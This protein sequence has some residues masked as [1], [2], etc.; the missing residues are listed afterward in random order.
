MKVIEIIRRVKIE[1]WGLLILVALIIVASM[2]RTF[3]LSDQCIVQ[4][5]KVSGKFSGKGGGTGVTIEFKYLNNVIKAHAIESQGCYP[6]REVGDTV[7]IKYSVRDPKVV[8]TLKC[9]YDE[10]KHGHLIGKKLTSDEI[11]KLLK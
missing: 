11:D 1:F 8:T 6:I 7:L 4:F 3:L 2:Y 9:Y 10:K 5:A